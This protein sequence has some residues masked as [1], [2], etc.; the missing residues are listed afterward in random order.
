MKSRSEFSMKSQVSGENRE[1]EDLEID[2][3]L[4]AL[5]QRYGYD[6]RNYARASMKRRIRRAVQEQRVKTI[7]GLQ[8]V[9][10]HNPDALHDFVSVLSVHVTSLFRDPKFYLKIRQEVVPLLRTYPF[11][12]VWIAGCATG[13]EVLSMAILLEEE[14]LKNKVRIYGTDISDELLRHAATGRFPLD[15]MKDY[16]QNYHQA[17]GKTDFSSYYRVQGDQVLFAPRLFENVVFSQHNLASDAA[18][19]E[20]QMVLCRNVMI[21]FDQ[22]LRDRVHQLFCNSLC[23]F[24]VL[25]L[26]LRES[27]RFSAVADCYDTIDADLRLYRRIR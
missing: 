11:V 15:R 3:L 13:E 8:E 22:T 5:A 24:G 18:F 19:N 1:L 7:S 4:T 9:L 27:I 6:F 26:G 23:L 17:G 21:Y 2:L 16:T 12:R 20:F 14:G 10:L 25:G